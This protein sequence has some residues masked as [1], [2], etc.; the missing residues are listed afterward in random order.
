MIALLKQRDFRFAWFGGFF[1][2]TGDWML[3]IALPI[4]L[5]ELTGSALT[6]SA[7]FAVRL[8]P[9]IAL[10]SLAGAYVDRW[11]RRRTLVI[12]NLAQIA[13]VV[14]LVAITSPGTVWIAFPSAFALS[15]LLRFVGPAEHALLPRLVTADE[16]PTANALNALNNNLAR[17]TGPAIGGVVMAA[18]GLPATV[19]LTVACHAVAALAFLAVSVDARPERSEP[20]A[21]AEPASILG[22]WLAGLRLIR[23]RRQ[24]RR[25]VALG[26]VGSFGEG[27]MSVMFVVWVADILGGGARELGWLMSA[28][29]VGGIAGGLLLG[30]IAGRFAPVKLLGYGAII[31]GALDLALFNYP[32]FLTGVWLGLVIIGLVGLPVVAYVTGLNT[33]L[34]QTV[35]DAYRGRVFGA[36]STLGSGLQLVGTGVA[37]LLGGVVGPLVLLNLQGGSYM[38]VGLLA[39]LMLTGSPAPEAAEPE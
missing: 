4:Y 20:P 19:A 35:E 3:F 28:Q 25:L 9:A 10:A 8:V 36:M 39:L 14:P 15:V 17:L 21:G 34:Q 2:L 7:L 6:T 23:R 1:A 24:V 12:A 29:A 30:Q 37:G 22:E 16:L 33:L 5:Y 31:F 13:A 26:S 18:V 11:D 38:L 27:I 32:R